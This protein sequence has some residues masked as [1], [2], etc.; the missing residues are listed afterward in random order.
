MSKRI[1]LHLVRHADYPLN[2]SLVTVFVDHILFIEQWCPVPFQSNEDRS[3]SCFIQF[4]LEMSLTVSE[5]REEVLALIDA[6][7][8]STV[9]VVA[10]HEEP[11][12]LL[13]IFSKLPTIEQM[14]IGR[15]LGLLNT[16]EIKHMPVADVAC[17]VIARAVQHG[18]ITAFMDLVKA[19][20][21]EESRKQP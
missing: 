16:Q 9:A 12:P 13:D 6:A 14:R 18:H 15:T 3:P 2:G 1:E 8:A 11:A 7:E 17:T 19:A 21:L 10:K 4:N 5:T 20:V